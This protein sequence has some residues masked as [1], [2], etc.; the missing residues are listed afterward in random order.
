[1]K[2]TAKAHVLC[3][4][5][6]LALAVF[7]PLSGAAGQEE[8]AAATRQDTLLAA[9]RDI[10]ENI[11]FCALITLDDSGHPRVRA[12]DP[13]LPDDNWIVRMGTN[14]NTRKA[15]EIRND[16]RVT[17]YYTHPGN[18]GYVIIYGT[19]K[20]LEDPKAKDE[21]FKEEW[22]QFYPDKKGFVVIEVT[23]DRLEVLDY[24]R[25]I[26]GAPNT[27]MTPTVTFGK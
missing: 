14:T 8:A 18:M 21:W 17:L 15:N 11:R 6:I 3:C 25:G 19:A 13:F 20:L 2:L 7:A 1:M 4:I 26:Q 22:A 5:G 16:S 24:T 9:A 23:P 10:M 12:M 27:W